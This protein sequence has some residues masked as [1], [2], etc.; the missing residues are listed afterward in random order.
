MGV[1]STTRDAARLVDKKTALVRRHADRLLRIC[2][3]EASYQA[4]SPPGI[5][6]APVSSSQAQAQEL[7]CSA[8]CGDM[9]LLRSC[10]SKSIASKNRIV[11]AHRIADPSPSSTEGLLTLLVSMQNL[12]LFM[13]N[14]F[15]SILQV[16]TCA[17][18]FFLE[19]FL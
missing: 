1:F 4:Y 15:P 13:P 10:G 2:C 11:L 19:T 12:E 16:N 18:I 5:E 8:F 3:A 17:T 9:P 7:R 14:I 6:T